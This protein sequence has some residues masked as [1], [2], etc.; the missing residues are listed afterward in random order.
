MVRLVPISEPEFRAWL[1]KA[2]VEYAE[3]KLR[4]G[5]WS[6]A[7]ALQRSEREFAELLPAGRASPNQ[8]IFSIQDQDLAANV[9]VLWFAVSDRGTRRS[10]F[11]YDFVI[12]EEFRRR[13][14]ATQAL[15]ALEE[16]VKELGIDTIGLHVFGHNHAARALYEKMGYV[17]TNVN[18]SKDL[19]AQDG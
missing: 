2:V 15:R 8:H 14:Y 6:A 17:V 19:S 7:D 4:S 13:G 5:N 1:E 16:K 10:A 3:D 12:F 18:M 9:G 11:V